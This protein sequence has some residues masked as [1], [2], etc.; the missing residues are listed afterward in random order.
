VLEL[1]DTL[2]EVLTVPTVAFRGVIEKK[3]LG[4]TM[5]TA[6]IS[7]VIFAYVVL[8]NPPHLFEAI[9]GL[10]R[11]SLHMAPLVFVWLSLFPLALVIQA[12]LFHAVARLLHGR[13]GYPGLLC[14]LCFATFPLV[15]FAPLA[16]IRALIDSTLGQVLYGIGSLILILWILWLHIAAVRQNY[17]FRLGRAIAT[18]LIPAFLAV[19]LLLA[20][21][22]SVAF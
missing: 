21:I 3:P 2:Y 17:G 6:L 9:L 15:F 22:L 5:V 10:K 8:P 14:G 19:V 13:G 4:R 1:L 20:A 12:G 16:L 11:G 7:S 18:C